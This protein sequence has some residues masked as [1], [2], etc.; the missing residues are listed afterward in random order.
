MVAPTGS[1]SQR[2]RTSQSAWFVALVLSKA[3]E[4]LWGRVVIGEANG[5]EERLV[6]IVLVERLIGMPR[7]GVFGEALRF[8]GE[9]ASWPA[10]QQGRSGSNAD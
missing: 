8:Q 3:C 4:W 7:Q 9:M 2:R 6:R 5:V 10:G 1:S